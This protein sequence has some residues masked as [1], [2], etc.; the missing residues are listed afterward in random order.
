[1][2]MLTMKCGVLIR[3]I[4]GQKGP[5]DSNTKPSI[6]MSFGEKYEIYEEIKKTIYDE[7]KG[8]NMDLSRMGKIHLDAAIAMYSDRDPMEMIKVFEQL[9]E[10]KMIGFLGSD[11]S[12]GSVNVDLHLFS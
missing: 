10:H 8:L 3:K 9:M 4:R 11:S 6:E 7:M 12:S 2:G 1:M 5:F